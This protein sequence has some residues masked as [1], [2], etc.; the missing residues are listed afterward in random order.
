MPA[1]IAVATS[2]IAGPV[3]EL[4]TK[5]NAIPMAA[6]IAPNNISLFEIIEPCQKAAADVLSGKLISNAKLPIKF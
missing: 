3:G 4:V 1:K 2:T 6:D 5:A